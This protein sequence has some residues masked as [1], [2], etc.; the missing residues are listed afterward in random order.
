MRSSVLQ[1]VTHSFLW[2][3]LATFWL[4]Y[5]VTFFSM[6]LFCEEFLGG[7]ILRYKHR[8]H[9]LKLL[10]WLQALYCKGCGSVLRIDRIWIWPIKNW[11]MIRPCKTPD[12]SRKKTGFGPIRYYELYQKLDPDPQLSLWKV[13]KIPFSIQSP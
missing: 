3:A 5:R 9:V 7:I 11:I 10:W 4:I 12:S 8:Y 1:F 13:Q 2:I 6:F